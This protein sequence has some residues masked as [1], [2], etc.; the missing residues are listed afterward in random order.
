MARKLKKDEATWRQYLGATRGRRRGQ[1]ETAKK[2]RLE[3]GRCPW[4]KQRRGATDKKAVASRERANPPEGGG[5]ATINLAGDKEKAPEKKER[6]GEKRTLDLKSFFTVRGTPTRK[7]LYESSVCCMKRATSKVDRGTAKERGAA[8]RLRVE[9]RLGE[10]E[11]SELKECVKVWGRRRRSHFAETGGRYRDARHR[12]AE[13][14][15]L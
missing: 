11:G 13:K 6:S 3:A 2:R 12:G 14:K 9:G 4:S 5:R 8:P 10:G 15:I 1:R 7:I